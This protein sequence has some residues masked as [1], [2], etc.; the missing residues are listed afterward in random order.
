M[1]LINLN[2]RLNSAREEEQAK[3]SGEL[4]DQLGQYLTAIRIDSVNT[5]KNVPDN[6]FELKKKLGGIVELVDG[7]IQR[8]KDISAKLRAAM[9]DE[10]GLASAFDGARKRFGERTGVIIKLDY[11]IGESNLQKEISTAMYR[12]FMEATTNISRH[13]K[14]KNVNCTITFE[15]NSYEMLIE[16]D[17]IGINT[18]DIFDQAS[19]G[20]FGMKQRIK[21]LNGNLEIGNREPNGTFVKISIPAA[22]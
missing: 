4:H 18:E 14:A 11:L 15:D 2:T 3:I 17:G 22:Q 12:I 1:E 9:L 7:A 16:D 13:A 20:I 21:N 10:L 5:L 6:L 19:L 8:T